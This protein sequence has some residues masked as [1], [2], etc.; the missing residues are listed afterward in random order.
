MTVKTRFAPSPTGLI[1][2]GNLRTAILNYL[3]CAKNDGVFL[4]RF[5]DTDR[6]R[7]KEEFVAA[8]R[9]DLEW[10]GIAAEAE[11]RQSER[12]ERYDA[13]AE[14]L[15]AA[16]LLYP[17][18][19]TSDELERRRKRQL[20]RG[21]PPIYDRA[22]LKLTDEQISQLRDEGRAP[23]WRFRLPNTA[24]SGPDDDLT[25]QPS[26][27]SW[28][29]LV[30]GPQTVDLGSLSDPVL[31]REDG[32]YLYTF[33]SV[34]DDSELDITHII[35]GEDHV[36][37]TGVQM[38]LFRALGAAPPAFGH[39]NLLVA[40]DGKALSKRLGS[41]SIQSLREQG[42]EAMAVL[43][44][45]A[46]IG[47]SDP[48][49]PHRSLAA[50]A[51]LFSPQKLSTAPAKFD[52]QELANL[53]AKLVHDLSFEDVKDRL[54]AMDVGGGAPFWDA[55]RGNLSTVAEA[56]RWWAVVTGPVTP[57]IPDAS[58]VETA[59]SLLPDEPFDETTWS[60]WTG[61]V[62]AETGAKGRALFMPLR[63]ALTGETSGPEMQLL[64]PF[65][66][67][68]TALKRLAGERC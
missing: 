17:C 25:P 41:L 51:D 60:A 33:T 57:E 19:E 49:E 13:A 5:D 16:G 66:G 64:L 26:P 31:I 50:L 39:H 55:V 44:H 22:G 9:D 61:R 23:H 35:R 30:K 3:F 62:K 12:T 52:P 28:D 36:T 18:F 15:R 59:A 47:T 4:L 11:V 48:I 10:L 63:Q 42:L 6:E 67:R 1:H 32:S 7:A 8:I 54:A 2:V 56:Q 14:R 43:S 38:A 45:A 68:Q 58:F 34:V 20:A 46:L 29:D 53:N 65:I 40:A 24:E 37:N 27:V 21:L